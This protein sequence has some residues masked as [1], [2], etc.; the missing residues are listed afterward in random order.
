MLGARFKDGDTRGARV[1]EVRVSEQRLEQLQVD[2]IVG[3]VVGPGGAITAA[4]ACS[5]CAI[6]HGTV[7]H[8]TVTSTGTPTR[9]SA[10]EETAS[11]LSVLP[12]STIDTSIG[13]EA[14]GWPW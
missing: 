7:M 14:N 3:A 8:G 9:A 10:S 2:K 5:F 13:T 12:A 4:H 11:K 1:C 6:C